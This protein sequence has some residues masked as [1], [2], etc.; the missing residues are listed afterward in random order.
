[1]RPVLAAVPLTRAW[2]LE[3]AL[4]DAW[5]RRNALIY[6]IKRDFRSR[7]RPA[8]LG[9]VWG[10]I[11]PLLLALVLAYSVGE[12]MGHHGAGR[13]DYALQTLWA[14]VPLGLFQTA[15]AAG[16]TAIFHNAPLV[17]RISGPKIYYPLAAVA[18]MAFDGIVNAMIACCVAAVLGHLH[19][20]AVATLFAGLALA[21]ALGL[22]VALAT[23][24]FAPRY[25]DLSFAVPTVNQLLF[26]V[27][28]VAFPLASLGA[29]VQRIARL[30][31]LAWPIELARCGF[32]GAPIPWT[33]LLATLAGSVA[34]LVVSAAL[35]FMRQSRFADEL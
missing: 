24:A 31:P 11:R 14:L 2:P 22:G 27:T 29:G 17:M 16:A 19:L 3:T 34:L 5:D 4:R 23:A 9:V 20:V 6:L 25:R 33:P 12:L 28:P 30:N 35:F 26:Y 32:T 7:F 10:F 1:M 21:G 18:V 13:Q 15:Y 8:R